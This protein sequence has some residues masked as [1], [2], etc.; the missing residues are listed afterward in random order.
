DADSSPAPRAAPI[1]VSP[2]PAPDVG[3]APAGQRLFIRRRTAILSAAAVAIS[4]IAALAFRSVA[5]PHTTATP[6]LAVGRIRDL[7]SPDSAR[8]GGVLSEMLATSLGR[9]NAVQVIANSRMLELTPRDA[10]TSR[11]A[12]TDAARRA[13]ATEVIE[14]ELIPLAGQ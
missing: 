8:L 4:V 14:G 7:V 6:I 1:L 9:M 12:L 2:D 11:S 10:D 3:P 13:G 5:A